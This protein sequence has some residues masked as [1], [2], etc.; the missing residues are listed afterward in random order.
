MSTNHRLN[1]FIADLFLDQ[2][3]L[4]RY[5]NGPEEEMSAAALSDEEQQVLRKGDFQIICKYC[6]RGSRPT[7]KEQIAGSGS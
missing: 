6:R 5:L 3:K 7:P 1:Q 2:D 4:K